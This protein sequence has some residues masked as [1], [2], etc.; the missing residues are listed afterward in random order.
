M[1]VIGEYKPAPDVSY[2]LTSEKQGQLLY[3]ASIKK[4]VVT[5]D[6]KALKVEP[7]EGVKK[8]DEIDFAAS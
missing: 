6:L 4:V 3:R 2:S 7:S 8:I 5:Y 1:S